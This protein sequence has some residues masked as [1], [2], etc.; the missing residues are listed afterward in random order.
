MAGTVAGGVRAGVQNK[1]KYGAD[2]YAR[3]GSLGGQKSRT[4]GFYANRELASVAGKIGGTMS[5]RRKLT[6]DERWKLRQRPEVLQAYER[7]VAIREEHQRTRAV[8]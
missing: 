7:L 3:I 5:R 4:G 6:E 2:F 1:T 8:R